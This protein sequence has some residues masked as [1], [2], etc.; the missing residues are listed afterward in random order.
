MR[1]PTRWDSGKDC[2][3]RE[4][5]TDWLCNQWAVSEDRVSHPSLDVALLLPKASED[6][7]AHSQSIGQSPSVAD[8]AV[9]WEQSQNIFLWPQCVG[10]RRLNALTHT[11]NSELVDVK[12]ADS[13]Q[14][15]FF[16]FF[17]HN[18][19]ILTLNPR[20]HPLFIS[21]ISRLLRIDRSIWSY[22]VGVSEIQTHTS[23]R[24]IRVPYPAV[25]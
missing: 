13:A 11:Q 3:D 14:F 16:S 21:E 1:R 6:L 4:G 22:S 15:F 7:L 23:V 20:A 5:E 19:F 12:V 24:Y 2:K 17:V 10:L 9:K 8:R 25:K 18:E